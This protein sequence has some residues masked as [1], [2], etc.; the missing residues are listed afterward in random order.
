MQKWY[1]QLQHQGVTYRGHVQNIGWQNY[2]SDGT[3]N[4]GLRVEALE[5]KIAKT[6]DGCS[7]A[8]FNIPTK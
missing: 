1:K 8:T 4:R 6:T 5:I 2:V 7:Y 3:D